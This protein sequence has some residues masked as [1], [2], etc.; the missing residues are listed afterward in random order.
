MYPIEVL[1]EHFS[2]IAKQ[3]ISYVTK[4]HGGRRAIQSAVAAVAA[5]PTAA[6]DGTARHGAGGGGACAGDGHGVGADVAQGR[7]SEVGAGDS[8]ATRGRSP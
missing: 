2:G 1:H 5:H 3:T 6:Q 7:L 8:E 4:A